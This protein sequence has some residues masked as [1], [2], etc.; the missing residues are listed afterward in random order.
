MNGYFAQELVKKIFFL[1]NGYKLRIT[2][3]LYIF[4]K[5]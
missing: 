5:K 3:I 1:L 4:T 2:L